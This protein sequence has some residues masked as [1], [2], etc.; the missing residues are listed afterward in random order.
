MALLPEF[1]ATLTSDDLARQNRFEVQIFP[2]GGQDS[3]VNMLCENATFPG[4][5]MRTTPDQLR[6]GP[7][8][9]FVHG[10]TYGPIS[11]TFICRPGLPEKR[12]FETWQELMFNR[13][14]WNVHY[15]KD[16]YGRIR[17]HQ[18]DRDDSQVYS[19]TI[20]EAYPKTITAQ[21]Y[22]LGSNDSYQT[23]QV[24]FGF[25]HWEYEDQSGRAAG[26][27]AVDDFS[28]MAAADKARQER[29]AAIATGV[30]DFSSV[31]TNEGGMAR[32]GAQTG[33]VDS[34]SSMPADASKT[35]ATGSRSASAATAKNVGR[36]YGSSGQR[37]AGALSGQMSKAA[38]AG[39]MPSTWSGGGTSAQGAQLAK[40]ASGLPMLSS[41]A[42][43]PF[44]GF[45]G[46]VAGGFLA[47]AVA[48]A[49]PSGLGSFAASQV[50]AL[51]TNPSAPSALNNMVG[52]ITG[53]GQPRTV[54]AMLP[55]F[56]ASQSAGGARAGT[57]G[58]GNASR[59][60]HVGAGSWISSGSTSSAETGAPVLNKACIT[61]NRGIISVPPGVKTTAS[62]TKNPNR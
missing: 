53:G 56:G 44:G 22:S 13:E 2:P 58:T 5:N 23:L 37:Q 10:V 52:A 16:Y 39:A 14:S 26:T 31:N 3:V 7:V 4:Q 30:D 11:L 40:N 1:M 47:G 59:T 9:E 49:L 8:R 41:R 29:E 51:V 27:G 18:L 38:D 57:R 34:F 28:G 15:Y 33:G 35:A 12:F 32:R 21:D 20:Y 62:W 19:V 36:S 45:V 24:E 25:H 46:Q 54:S 61:V 48:N 60:H 6:Y 50:G 55:N 43:S 17:L 42:A